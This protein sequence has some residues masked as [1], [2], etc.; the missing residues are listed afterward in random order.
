MRALAREIG[1]R[2]DRLEEGCLDNLRR[3]AYSVENGMVFLSLAG[4]LRQACG[5]LENIALLSAAL[6]RYEWA[7]EPGAAVRPER[8]E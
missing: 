3:G 8:Q 5:R 1:N 7:G 4:I 2:A 6:G